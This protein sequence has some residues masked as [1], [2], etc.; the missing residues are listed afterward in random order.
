MDGVWATLNYLAP[1]SVRNRL[2]VAPGGHLTTTRYAPQRVRIANGRDSLDDFGLDQSGFALLEHRSAV[3]DFGDATQLD[4]VYVGEALDLVR[5]VT[6][7][8]EVLSLGWVIRRAGPDLH[9][10]QP[11]ASDVHVDL[12]PGRASTRFQAMPTARSWRRA[13]MTSLWRA[14][15][16]PPQDWPLGLLDYRSV[17]DEEGEANLL[18]FVDSL[19]DPDDVPNIDDPD[20]EPAGSIFAYRP[21]HRWWYFPD[22]HAGEALILKLHD[23]DHSVAWRAPHTAFHDEAASGAHPRESVEIRTVAFFY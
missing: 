18:L 19:P 13:L 7:A 3:T 23:T 5:Q 10:A 16:P 9:G 20:S 8:D 21:A 6:G 14:F 12:H 15:S 22:M 17:G 4:S 1:D 2:Y 11:P